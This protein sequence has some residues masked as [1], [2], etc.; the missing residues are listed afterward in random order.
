MLNSFKP[1]YTAFNGN[2]ANKAGTPSENQMKL[3]E[4]FRQFLSDG[5]S[6]QMFQS[7][8]SQLSYLS[9]TFTELNLS[10]REGTAGYLS[11]HS[12]MEIIVFNIYIVLILVVFIL[13]WMPYLNGLSIKIWRT[14][15]MLNMIPMEV[16]NKHESLKNAFISGD[17]LEA[18]K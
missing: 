10:L 14:K 9:P 6:G 12:K 8:Q 11:S 7:V 5:A 16:I 15:G 2:P 13:I 1:L 17:I 4:L 3:R 18:V